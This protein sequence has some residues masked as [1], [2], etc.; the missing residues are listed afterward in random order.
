MALHAGAISIDI[1]VTGYPGKSVCHG[2]LGWSTIALLRGSD[3]VALIDVGAFAQRTLLIEGLARNG[4][5]PADV[6]DVVLTHSHW[7]HAINWVLFPRAEIWIGAAELDWAVTQ[8]DGETPV[9]ELYVRALRDER[10]LQRVRPGET[11]PPGLVSHAAPGHTPGHLIFTLDGGDHDVIFTG[12]AAKNRAELLSR[13]A[14]MTFD[15]AISRASIERIWE[16]WRARPGNVVVPGHDIPMRLDAA[17]KPQ[18]LGLREAAIEA[19]FG[20]DLDTTTL[21]RL[22]PG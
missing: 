7:D 16:L 5:R 17:G 21:F 2:G 13:T 20:D 15:P 14:D 11:V 19:W 22:A 12:D 4:L 10:R 9:P 3:R 1:L 6:T 18:P 8:P